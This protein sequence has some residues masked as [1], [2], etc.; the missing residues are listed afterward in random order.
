LL[1]RFTSFC[2]LFKQGDAEL[3][4]VVTHHMG[5]G[6]ANVTGFDHFAGTRVA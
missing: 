4:S 1:P 2:Q 5:A 3:A 6:K